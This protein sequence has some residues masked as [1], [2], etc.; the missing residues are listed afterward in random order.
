MFSVLGF[1]S[2]PSDESL[3]RSTSDFLE[4]TAK[5]DEYQP[6]GS[7]SIHGPIVTRGRATGVD[8]SLDSDALISAKTYIFPQSCTCSAINPYTRAGA[9]LLLAPTGPQGQGNDGSGAHS[10]CTVGATPVASIK[11][12]IEQKHGLP[13]PQVLY[14]D[15]RPLPSEDKSAA[16]P[17]TSCIRR[18]VKA[19]VHNTRESTPRD[20]A[21]PVDSGEMIHFVESGV[22]N[23]GTPYMQAPLAGTGK[24]AEEVVRVELEGKSS[25]DVGSQDRN[26]IMMPRYHHQIWKS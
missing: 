2:I 25:L 14:S 9:G 1:T 21:C 7:I 10:G 8:T 19:R 26:L 23:M 24:L 3:Q 15:N 11:P 6:K 16:V 13:T 4:C 12:T 20:S 22:R 17:C 18:I 5:S